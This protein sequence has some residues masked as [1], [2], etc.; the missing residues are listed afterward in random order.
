MTRISDAERHRLF[1]A[2][3]FGPRWV[4][5]DRPAADDDAAVS[6]PE[7]IATLD[8]EALEATVSGCDA[9]RL[10]GTRTQTVFGVGARRPRWMVIGEAPGAE[11]DATGEPFVGQAGKLLDAMLRAAGF[12]R[13]HDVYIANVLKCRPPGNRNPTPEEMAACRPFLMRQIALADPGLILVVGKIA[14]Q[15]LLQTEQTVGEARGKV[16][17]LEHGDASWPL[18]VTYHPAYLL[19][20]LPDKAKAWVDLCLARRT[21][22][23]SGL[24][25]P[26]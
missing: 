6:R 4:L 26:G 24:R 2:M 20:T 10:A 11:E 3:G 22:E 1:D 23:A 19:R 25:E 14:M 13:E 17:R 16:H 8:W 21:L 7:R 18:V 9:C 12:S 15:A 5:R